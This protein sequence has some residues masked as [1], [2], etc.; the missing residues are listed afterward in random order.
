MKFPGFRALTIDGM[1]SELAGWLPAF[2]SP[3]QLKVVV[4]L[5]ELLVRAGLAPVPVTVDQV[6]EGTG[7]S[8]QGAVSG[9]RRAVEDGFVVRRSVKGRY[10]YGLQFGDGRRGRLPCVFTYQKDIQEKLGEEH[11]QHAHVALESDPLRAKGYRLLVEEF[12][13]AARTAADIAARYDPEVVMQQV[14]YAR[15]AIANGSVRNKAAYLVARI[16]D[17][18]GPP[19]GSAP[20]PAKR[21]YTEEEERLYFYH[22]EEPVERVADD[23]N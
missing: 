9:L 12:G 21:W 15:L 19:E 18:W 1:W 14:E 10:E 6:Q 11:V 7:L 17:D 23:V 5:L 20:A 13:V 8:R 3:A 16:R 22:A 4:F 2:E